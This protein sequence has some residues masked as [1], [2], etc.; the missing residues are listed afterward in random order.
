VV[1]E[2]QLL[3]YFDELKGSD[4]FR[5]EFGI[6]HPDRVALGGIIIGSMRTWI[7]GDYMEHD[8][9]IFFEKAKRIRDAY[10]YRNHIKLV[11]WDSV[12]QQLRPPQEPVVREEAQGP[13]IHVPPSPPQVELP[14]P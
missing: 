7:R 4:A 8:R 2:N 10:F 11:T 6:L 9:R 3:N 1:A 13:V 5:A 12:L 14:Q